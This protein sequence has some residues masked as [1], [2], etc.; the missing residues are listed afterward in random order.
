[1]R[2]VEEARCSEGALKSEA[3]REI[4]IRACLCTLT[5]QIVDKYCT[6]P[7]PS[8]IFDSTWSGEILQ[9]VIPLS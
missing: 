2:A 5:G 4:F 1:M 7:A 9:C 8:T 6:Q 3:L